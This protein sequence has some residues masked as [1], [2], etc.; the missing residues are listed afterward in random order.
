MNYAELL[1]VS[2][3]QQAKIAELKKELE[4]ALYFNIDVTRCLSKIAW[5]HNHDEIPAYMELSRKC[6]KS[7]ESK[8]IKELK[9]RV[10]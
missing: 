8:Q 10:K 2:D 1:A 9:E 6:I 3:K 5:E 7:I 4:S